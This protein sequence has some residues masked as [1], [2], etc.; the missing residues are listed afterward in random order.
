[1]QHGYQRTVRI[2]GTV[3][4][5]K[6]NKLRKSEIN[7]R[8]MLFVVLLHRAYLLGVIGVGN[9]SAHATLLITEFLETLVILKQVNFLS[10]TMAIEKIRNCIGYYKNMRKRKYQNLT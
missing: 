9:R 10:S 1:M 6:L 4:I 2:E 8:C 3:V 5:E 7:A